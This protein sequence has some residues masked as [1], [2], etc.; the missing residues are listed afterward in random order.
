MTK[1]ARIYN[2]EETVSSITDVRKTRQLYTKIMELDQF[3]IPNAKINS[4]D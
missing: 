1:G 3:L 2:G 4:V